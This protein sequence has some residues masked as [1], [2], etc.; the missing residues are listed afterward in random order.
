MQPYSSQSHAKVLVKPQKSLLINEISHTCEEGGARLKISSWHLLIKLKNNYSLKKL[1]KWT[2][3]KRKNFHFYIQC[4][5][6]LKNKT[7]HLEISLFYTGVP[8]ILMI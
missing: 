2:Y 6:F 1:L 3:K 5:I 4:Y 8:K 7:T